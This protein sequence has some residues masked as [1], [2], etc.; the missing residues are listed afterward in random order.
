MSA[1]GVHFASHWNPA[2]SANGYVS[3]HNVEVPHY[4]PDA[5][6]PSYDP[7]LHPPNTGPFYPV[8]ENYVHHA[9]SSS[10]DRQAFQGIDGGFVDLTM[11]HG[12]GPHKRKSPGVPSVCER[13]SSSRY[14]G[15]GSSSDIPM[16][17]EL[18]QEKP[19]MDS[20][21][22]PWDRVSMA[23]SYRSNALSI[24]S[25]GSMRNVRS[26]PAL[27]LESNLARAHLPINPSH[28]SYSTVHHDHTSS[29]DP[30]LPRSSALP[31]EW[32]HSRI[33]PANGRIQVSGSY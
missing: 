31:R 33:S 4:Q 2:P 12:R 21:H 10:Y 11:G 16:P 29:M 25:E 5:S 3:N 7:F 13:G 15:A 20:Q 24:R 30:S 17:P 1:E 22:M 14:Y 19:N 9:A 32:H 6:G 18:W 8:P 28:N 27:D 23:P 26:R